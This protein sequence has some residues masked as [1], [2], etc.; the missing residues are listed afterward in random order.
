MKTIAVV[1]LG[2]NGKSFLQKFLANVV[3][4]STSENSF[5]VYAD[6]ASTDESVSY[7][8]TH[9]PQVKIVK[10]EQNEGFA[11]GY[12]QALKHVNADYYVLLNQDVE[13]TE[14]WLTPLFEFL[15]S[16][17]GY[18]IVQPKLRA[19]HEPQ[20]FEYAGASGGYI[21][22]LGYAFC[23]GRL[24][25]AIEK[26]INQYDHI[27]DIF[28]A[29]G[30]A[31]MICAT[32]FHRLDGFDAAFFAHQEEIDLCWRV[33]NE[34]F[35]IAVIPQSVVYHIGG[36][37][38]PQ[39][40]PRK[41]FLNFRNNLFMLVKNLPFLQLMWVLP[42]RFFLDQLAMIYSILKNKNFND[43]KAILKAH[44]YFIVG[45]FSMFRKRS[46]SKPSLHSTIYAKSII[47]QYF[48]NKKRKFSELI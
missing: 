46:Y 21:D 48:V 26:D 13:V 2:W 39:G 15:E 31:M 6:N 38:L 44:L 45:S 19:F 8:E 17:P 27:E 34:G 7:V 5:V 11:E 23:R 30:A 22:F 37:S 33:Q 4:F 40:N 32:M 43:A 29:S 20:N 12:N 10:N 3:Q 18:A 28:W 41:T 14:G 47:W 1:I 9:F 35:K 24:F 25:D 42:L 36:G 16:H